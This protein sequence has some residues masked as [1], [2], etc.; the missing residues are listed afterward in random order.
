MA[1]NQRHRI[2]GIERALPRLTLRKAIL[3]D[4]GSGEAEKQ[5]AVI[6]KETGGDCEITVIGWRVT[7]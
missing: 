4:D 2:D 7:N 1:R 3:W 6:E 5:A